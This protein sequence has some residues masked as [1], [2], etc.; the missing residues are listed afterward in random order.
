MGILPEEFA[1]HGFRPKRVVVE[2]RC[3][4]GVTQLVE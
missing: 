3:N 4:A 1:V 2:F